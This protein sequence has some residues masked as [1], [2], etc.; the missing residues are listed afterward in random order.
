MCSRDFIR[1]RIF[2]DEWFLVNIHLTRSITNYIILRAAQPAS[3]QKCLLS[4][5]ICGI[6]ILSQYYWSHVLEFWL[7]F[8]QSWKRTIAKKPF[9]PLDYMAR[10]P[11]ILSSIYCKLVLF[12]IS[13]I[14]VFNKHLNRNRP[15]VYTWTIFPTAFSL[16]MLIYPQTAFIWLR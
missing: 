6:S 7:K 5:V 8:L 15:L 16:L 9:L 1:I 10:H 2:T 3:T 11:T 14:Y 4:L 13:C 12:T